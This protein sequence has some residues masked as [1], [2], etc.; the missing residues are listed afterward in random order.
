MHVVTA[1]TESRAATAKISAQET[2]LG[3]LHT[4]STS[5][6]ILSITSKPLTEFAFGTAFFSLS[7]L[8]VSSRRIEPSHPYIYIYIYDN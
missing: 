7:M 8:G 5:D 6:L 2:R 1:T 4:L 3:V